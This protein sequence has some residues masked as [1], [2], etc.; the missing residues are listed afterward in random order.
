LCYAIAL[1]DS[2][3]RCLISLYS[4]QALKNADG[5]LH[6]ALV[7]EILHQLLACAESGNTTFVVQVMIQY[8]PSGLTSLVTSAFRGIGTLSRIVSFSS[9]FESRLAD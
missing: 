5:L 9:F 3:L 6:L 7:E 2:E 8:C 1:P 4:E